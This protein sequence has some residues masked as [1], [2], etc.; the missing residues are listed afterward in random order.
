MIL[1][2]RKSISESKNIN[3]AEEGFKKYYKKIEEIIDLYQKIAD[4]EGTKILD[5]RLTKQINDS[6]KH[7]YENNKN[8]KDMQI[9]YEKY[10]E[11][12]NLEEDYNNDKI[13]GKYENNKFVI[14]QGEDIIAE[15]DSK[16]EAEDNGYVLDEE[17]LTTKKEEKEIYDDIELEEDNNE[18]E[19]EEEDTTTDNEEEIIRKTSTIKEATPKFNE[20]QFNF[21]DGKL[22]VDSWTV[23]KTDSKQE[24]NKNVVNEICDIDD[25]DDEF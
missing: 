19:K 17:L 13:T 9:A 15:Y 14:Y 2:T 3:E 22:I 1:K 11:E 10:N 20:Q 18:Q 25:V 12:H 16:A 8:D 4:I 5:N 7:L 23:V 6:V 21:Q 24:E